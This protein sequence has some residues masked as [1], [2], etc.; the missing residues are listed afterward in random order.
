LK[1]YNELKR[2][3]DSRGLTAT[4]VIKLSAIFVMSVGFVGVML[5][6]GIAA[7]FL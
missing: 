2:W 6:A 1:K 3:L 4:D 7:L 5:Y